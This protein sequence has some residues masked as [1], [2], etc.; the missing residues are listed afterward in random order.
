MNKEEAAKGLIVAFKNALLGETDFFEL[1]GF[2]QETV[3][4]YRIFALD[5]L[6]VF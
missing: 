5:V 1:A 4:D 6:E 2:T 3:H